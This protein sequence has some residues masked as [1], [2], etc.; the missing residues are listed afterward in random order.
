M[1]E[2][3]WVLAPDAQGKGYATEGVG[4]A[5]AWGD[6]HVARSRSFCIIHP[7]HLASI[8]VAQ[9]CGFTEFARPFYQT[10]PTILFTRENLAGRG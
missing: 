1:P 3:G 4:A 2:L 5:V 7:E 9:K 10:E 6:A 8:R